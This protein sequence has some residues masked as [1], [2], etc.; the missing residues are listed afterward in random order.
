VVVSDDVI[1]APGEAPKKKPSQ[2]VA[3]NVPKDEPAAKSKIALEAL[4]MAPEEA[5]I[6]ARRKSE[7]RDT[8]TLK[9]TREKI[10]RARSGGFHNADDQWLQTLSRLFA[11]ARSRHLGARQPR[12]DDPRARPAR[13]SRHPS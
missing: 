6:P 7:S 10:A 1:E 11:C 2:F 5:A 9:P 13:R 12:R 3:E 4:A 8:T